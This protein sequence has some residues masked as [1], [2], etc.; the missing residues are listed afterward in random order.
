M[1]IHFISLGCP[2]NLVDTEIMLGQLI[3]AGHT[4]LSDPSGAD[5]VVVNTCSFIEPA[6]DESIDV[7]LEMGEWKKQTDGGRLIVAGC[8][9]Q[10]YGADLI[11][12][13][14]EV[15][16]FLGTGGFDR[17][18]LAAEGSLNG[19]RVVLPNP[20]RAPVQD[21]SLPRF[22]T[23]PSHTAYLKIA[24]GCSSRCT[25]CIIPKLR[26]PHRSRPMQEVL[27][28]ARFLVESGVKELI[29]VAQNTAAYGRDLGLD[30]GLAHLLEAL[31]RISGLAWIRV[32]YGHP[33]YMS[34]ALIEVVGSHRQLCSYFDIP[35]QHI[36]ESI[37]KRM[38]R[39]YDS[40]TIFE[41]FERIRNK[42][43]DAALR[44]TLL[45]GFPGESD[46][47]FERL[48]NLVERV[49]FD[50]L[51]AFVYSDN[52]DL[53]S[54]A[55][56]NHVP[57][58]TKQERLD[59]LML[60]QRDISKDNSQQYVG[61]TL[62]VLIDGPVEG[63]DALR[64]RTCFQAPEIDGMVYVSRKG[65]EP[66]AFARVRITEAGEYDLRGVIA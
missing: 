58:V 51:G 24:E 46:D 20:G 19:K 54:S 5:C 10:R 37:L 28:E 4:I 49:R 59:L 31:T 2:R 8:L 15:D 33:D 7:I 55:L 63:T 60:L 56:S 48:L 36:S 16:V 39:H 9:P 3:E 57:E 53:P 29:L 13:L 22:Q 17:I 41:L 64:G 42:V 14:P 43:P 38:G 6:V 47:D 34:D 21:S 12:T 35:V 32:L 27:S 61:K 65:A 50:H 45:V 62:Q 11:K 44:T 23:T 40:S 25:Y 66:D 18:V 1:R 52:K 26:G 30:N